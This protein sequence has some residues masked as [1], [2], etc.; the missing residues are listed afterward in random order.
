MKVDRTDWTMGREAPGKPGLGSGSYLRHEEP[1]GGLFEV[2]H[3]G[4]D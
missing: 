1:E 3:R 4:H 2:S